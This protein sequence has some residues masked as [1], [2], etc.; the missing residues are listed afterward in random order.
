MKIYAA[1]IVTIYKLSIVFKSRLKDLKS[2]F[3][4]ESR[5]DYRKITSHRL[6]IYLVRASIKKNCIV[7]NDFYIYV[8]LN[9]YFGN[10]TIRSK[11]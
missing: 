5:A 8:K 7:I 9:T 11:F 1:L 2:R 4:S 6:I 3:S 10:L